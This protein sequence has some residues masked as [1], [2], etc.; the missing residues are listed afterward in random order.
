MWVVAWLLGLVLAA[1]LA[2]LADLHLGDQ[3]RLSGESRRERILAA[4]EIKRPLLARRGTIYDRHGTDNPLADCLPGW[5]VFLDP[6]AVATNHSRVRIAERV[7]GVLGLDTDAVLVQLKNTETRRIDLAVT[8]N[9]LVTALLADKAEISGVGAEPLYVRHYTEGRL[10]AH[11]LGAANTR[12]YGIAGIE[13]KYE[14][15]LHCAD[16]MI[17]SKADGKRRELVPRRSVVIRPIDGDDVFLTIDRNIQ[18]GVERELADVVQRFGAAGAWAIVQRVQ[19]GEILAMASLIR[20][21]LCNADRDAVSFWRN[22]AISTSY[23]PGSTMKA[24][25]VAAAMNERLV[26][27]D[28][29]V[30]TGD[31]TITIGGVTIHDHV[32]GTITVATGV[33]KSSNVMAVQL[34]LQLGD[35]RFEAYLR[36]FG[37]GSRAGIDLPAEEPGWFNPGS[38]QWTRLAI[39]ETSIGQSVAVTALQLLG[40]YSTIAN[41]GRLMRPYIVSRVVSPSGEIMHRGAPRVMGRPIRPEIAATLRRVL[42]AVTEEGGTAARLHVPGFR[43]AGKTGTAQIPIPGQGYSGTDFWASFVG[44]LPAEAP[45]FAAIVVVERPQPLHTGGAVAAPTFGR[46]AEVTAQCLGLPAAPDADAGERPAALAAARVAA[47]R[48]APGSAP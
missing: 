4:R 27:P 22:Q 2:R 47:M 17:Y 46:I 24:L 39:A 5:R 35:A 29:L 41:D 48:P 16:G 30:H 9:E 40:V 33:Q 1:L 43:V 36:A 15:N 34:G 42:A 3:S 18:H 31:G 45:E 14:S 28:S 26:T 8:T 7:A 23:E 13:R 21:E 10:A 19:T 25:I 44:F 37:L 20:D 12:G 6:V 11:V 32:S 38:R